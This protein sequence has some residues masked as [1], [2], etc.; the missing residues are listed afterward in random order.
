MKTALYLQY[1]VDIYQNNFLLLEGKRR[2]KDKLVNIKKAEAIQYSHWFIPKIQ[3][4][5]REE[6]LLKLLK[7][8]NGDRK[9][10][11]KLNSLCAVGTGITHLSEALGVKLI[12]QSKKALFIRFMI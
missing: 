2:W 1:E 6:F 11:R 10:K 12:C 3:A 5:S 4:K 8:L 7:K 9:E